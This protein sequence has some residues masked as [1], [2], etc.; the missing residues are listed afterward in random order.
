MQC[1][2]DISAYTVVLCFC[3]SAK[4]ND[5]SV[6]SQHGAVVFAH[7]GSKPAAFASQLNQYVAGR[8]PALIGAQNSRLVATKTSAQQVRSARVVY[9][10]CVQIILYQLN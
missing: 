5:N 4:Q 6:R 8:N 3:Y 2:S 10:A 9:D 7:V 1:V